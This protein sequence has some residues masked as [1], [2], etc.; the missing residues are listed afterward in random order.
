MLPVQL[1]LTEWTECNMIGCFC[2]G[3][4]SSFGPISISPDLIVGGQLWIQIHIH[5]LPLDSKIGIASSV[6][7]AQL[8]TTGKF[9]VKW[10][11]FL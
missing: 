7:S 5:L 8:S 3:V 11:Q 9:T 10:C 1:Q 6:I 2:V 4:Y